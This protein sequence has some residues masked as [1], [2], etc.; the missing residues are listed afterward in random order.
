MKF[1]TGNDM[2]GG[3]EYYAKQNKAPTWVAQS[4]KSLPLAQVMISGSWDGAH[5]GLHAQREG[6]LLL[7]LPLPR[8]SL[9]HIML[10]NIS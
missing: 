10:S 6:S 5:I 9:I 8:P 4:V 7:P 3:R 2:D 1:V